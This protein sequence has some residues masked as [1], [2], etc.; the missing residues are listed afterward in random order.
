MAD[1]TFR[2]FPENE[3]EALAMLYVQNQDLSGV[4]PEGLLDMYQD[5]YQ[6]INEHRREKRAAALQPPF[7]ATGF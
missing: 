5:A 4:T 6:K 3:I 2:T 1:N 7:P